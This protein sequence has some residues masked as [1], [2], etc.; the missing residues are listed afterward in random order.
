MPYLKSI[1]ML[2]MSSTTPLQCKFANIFVF[3]DKLFYRFLHILQT[4]FLETRAIISLLGDSTVLLSDEWKV[5][6]A[7][8]VTKAR[9]AVF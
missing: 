9:R 4:P 2:F 3:L 5:R 1:P 6:S 7:E 8:P